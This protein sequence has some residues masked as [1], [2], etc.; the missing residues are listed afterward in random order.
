[1]ITRSHTALTHDQFSPQ[2]SLYRTGVFDT[3]QLSNI[4]QEPFSR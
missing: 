4:D 1:M 2:L 3:E